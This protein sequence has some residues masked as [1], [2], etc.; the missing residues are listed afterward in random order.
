[1]R[2]IRRLA[3]HV[4]YSG[5]IGNLKESKVWLTEDVEDIFYF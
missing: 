2:L 3:I 1:M 5:K 4:S